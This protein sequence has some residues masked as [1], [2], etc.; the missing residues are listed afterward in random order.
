MSP[1]ILW[2]IAGAAFL[3]LE[4]FGIPGIGFLFIGFGALGT[5]VT[6]EMGLINGADYISHL[7]TFFITSTAFTALL[8]KRL[9]QWRIGKDTYSNMVGD[10]AIVGKDGLIKGK[11]G[12]V[13]W[14]GTTMRAVLAPDAADII[15]EHTSVTIVA[16]KGNILT[17]K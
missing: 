4:A 15:N 3:A 5:A 2:L 7:A 14:S 12:T 17:V 9:K 16:V 13:Q 1:S 10:N 11:E 8:W 6:I